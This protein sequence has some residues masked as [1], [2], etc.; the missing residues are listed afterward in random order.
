MIKPEKQFFLF[1]MGNRE[2]Y[3]YK[4]G[5]QLIKISTNEVIYSFD[6]LRERFFYDR[7]MIVIWTND[8]KIYQL[9]E[10]SYGVYLEDITDGKVNSRELITSG[11]FINLPDFED[12]KY[13][14]QLRILNHEIL[15]SFKNGKPVPNIYVYT[16][17]W[18]RDGAMMAMCLEKTKNLHLMRDWAL[19]VTDLYDRN[20]KGNCEPDNLGQLAFILSYFVDKNYPLILEIQK[21][22]DRI[23]ENGLLTGM[24]DYSHHEIYS[25]L[26]LKL[27]YERL[28]MDTSAIKIPNEFDSYAR[29]FWMDKNDVELATPYD[30]PYDERYPYLS[31]AR[32]HFNGDEIPKELLLLQYPMSWE[33]EASEAIYEDIAPLSTEYAKNK[34]G[35]PHSWHA[36]EMFLYL[37]EMK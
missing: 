20:N 17:P 31:W 9:Y 32:Y 5:G 14:E 35:A 37:I 26:W 8:K 21:E 1:G 29:M 10:N 24:T 28:N 30:N 27:A 22:A 19:S 18:Y 15:I 6:I 12:Y 4:E 34:C 25:T 7:Y 11:D 33:I 2:K 16:N 3:V 23:M 36:A 13:P